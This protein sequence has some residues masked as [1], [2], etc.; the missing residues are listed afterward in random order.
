MGWRTAR[1]I[2]RGEHTQASFLVRCTIVVFDAPMPI[3]VCLC[4]LIICALTARPAL[5]EQAT[6]AV[7]A[8]FANAAQELVSAFETAHPHEI[9]LVIG[10]TGKLTAQIIHGAPYDVFLAA[11]RERPLLLVTRKVAVEGSQFTYARG[12]L[13]LWGKDTLPDN[14]DAVFNRS[15]TAPLALANPDLAPYGRAAQQVLDSYRRRGM[16]QPTVITAE[17]VGQVYG[18]IASGNVRLGFVAVSQLTRQ[19]GSIAAH[20]AIPQE[21]YDPILQDG[22]LLKRA[23]NNAAARDFV[24]FLQSHGS[25]AITARLGYEAVR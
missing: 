14:L 20:I 4:V 23:G 11:D 2:D 10:S 13:A 24:A 5:A 15:A 18:M 12:R 8:N 21:L 7:A 3:F 22:V 9:T 16:E 17:S 19:D 25:M 6:V 1:S